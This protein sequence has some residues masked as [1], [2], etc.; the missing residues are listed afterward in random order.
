[1]S[2]RNKSKVHPSPTRRDFLKC[3][4]LAG[5][6]V[7]TGSLSAATPH[8]GIPVRQASSAGPFDL[9]EKDISGL[10]KAMESG[11]ETARSIAEKY[12]ERIRLQSTGRGPRSV[13]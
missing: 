12:L 11:A 3:G 1:M 8:P 10:Q 13:R 2:D 6:A 4:G 9:D 5:A 7:L